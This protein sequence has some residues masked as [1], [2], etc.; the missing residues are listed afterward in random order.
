MFIRELKNGN[1]E[2]FEKC[3]DHYNE[4]YQNLDI[5]EFENEFYFWYEWADKE[6]FEK[7]WLNDACEDVTITKYDNFEKAVN[8]FIN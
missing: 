3:D 4:T 7:E 1:T 6:L 5:I 8:I 2:I